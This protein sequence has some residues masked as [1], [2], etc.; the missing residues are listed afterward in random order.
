MTAQQFRKMDDKTKAELRMAYAVRENF[1]A[2]AELRS[3]EKYL[4]KRV[5]V[6]KGRK[7][8]VGTEGTVFWIGMRNYSKYGNWWS[9][10][11]RIGL[12]TDAGD[13]FF[14]AEDNVELCEPY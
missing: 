10:T 4:D 9:W 5:K 8:P 12:K 6:V 1:G 7:V 2:E 11:V 3:F 14:T 13:T